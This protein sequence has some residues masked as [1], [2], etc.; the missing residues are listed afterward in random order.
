MKVSLVTPTF[1]MA[2]FLPQAI[3]SVLAQQV[4]EL[5]YQVADGGSTD[6]TRE[7][8]ESYGDR[9][10]WHS[11][12]DAGAADALRTAFSQARG[13][14]F[15]WLNA[16][17]ILLPGALLAAIDAFKTHPEAVA[18]FSGARWVDEQANPIRPYPVAPDAAARLD[19]EC[20]I[21]QPACFFRAAAYRVAGGI[22]PTLS[23]AFD[24][25]LWI[26]LARL[27]PFL[28]QPGA[29]AMSRMHGLNKTLGERRAMFREGIV[30]LARHFGYV[31]FNWVYCRRVY[32]R[33]GNDQFA[34]PLS[35]SVPAY[36]A[37]LPE[38]LF[39]NRAAPRRY[40]NEWSG[41]ITLPGLRRTVSRWRAS[42]PPRSPF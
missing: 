25:D 34:V 1:R 32:E 4:E 18:V 12:P 38:G 36:L 22:D 16:D 15:G 26:R 39:I 23:S 7:I 35:P 24:Y 9:L 29:W 5:D 28:H 13:D 27:G 42:S 6:G 11:A 19:Q 14:I 30:V 41:Q 37:S 3:D 10:R 17:D 8:L 31:P 20:L 21:C 33:D 40:W 2:R